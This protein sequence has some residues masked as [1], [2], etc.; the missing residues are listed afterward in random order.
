MTEYAITKKLEISSC[1][2]SFNC[3]LRKGMIW[4]KK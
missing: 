1:L 3:L 4:D 2:G